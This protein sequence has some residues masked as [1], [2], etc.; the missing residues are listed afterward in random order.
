M[1]GNRSTCVCI[2]HRSFKSIADNLVRIY[3]EIVCTIANSY[4][5]PTKTTSIKFNEKRLSI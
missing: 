5:Y 1:F 3:D 2:F 4:G